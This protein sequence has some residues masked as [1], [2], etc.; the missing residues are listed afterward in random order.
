MYCLTEKLVK[1]LADNYRVIKEQL[2]KYG[3]RALIV[4]FE[5]H[6]GT[7]CGGNSL[8]PVGGGGQ[9]LLN[10]RQNFQISDKRPPPPFALK[11]AVFS[12]L[13]GQNFRN[14]VIFCEGGGRS[15]PAPPRFPPLG[16][17]KTTTLCFTFQ[18]DNFG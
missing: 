5:N 2:H 18:T 9:R 10:F 1:I 4:C 13:L 7:L 12:P 3:S 16:T 15:P 8:I 17:L 6:V 11:K 14:L